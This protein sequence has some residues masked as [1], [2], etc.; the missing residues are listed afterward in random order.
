MQRSGRQAA[1]L[2]GRRRLARTFPSIALL[3]RA[4]CSTFPKTWS[5][6]DDTLDRAPY[7][8]QD[9]SQAWVGYPGTQLVL[10]RRYRNVSEQRILLPNTTTL[11]GDNFVFMMTQGSNLTSLGRFQPLIIRRRNG[12]PPL[13]FT[14]F[15]DLT[16][17]T[18]EDVLGTLHWARWTNGTCGLAFR[19][20]DAACPVA[21]P[22]S[23]CSR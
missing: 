13:P 4:A 3:R 16:I 22:A 2:R 9:L 12:E 5:E 20:L 11:P 14:S 15:R 23:P 6:F 10:E 19:R 1:E 8:Q 18:E 7:V 21:P 17:T